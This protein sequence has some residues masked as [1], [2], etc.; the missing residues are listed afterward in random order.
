MHL[1]NTRE[2]GFT[3]IE[4]MI[5]IIIAMVLLTVALPKYQDYQ[6]RAKYLSA[7]SQLGADKNAV[8][9]TAISNGFSFA[10]LPEE[11]LDHDQIQQTFAL[12]DNSGNP[13]VSFRGGKKE[14]DYD[15]MLY[16]F[17][18]KESMSSRHK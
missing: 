13:Y 8:I 3:L 7:V 15:Y 10:K 14:S 1:H 6:V 4:L 16:Q 5:C 9:S 2:A 18:D 17:V 12:N 11:Q